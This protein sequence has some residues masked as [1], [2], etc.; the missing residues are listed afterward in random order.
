MRAPGSPL[1]YRERVRVRVFKYN[2]ARAP[3]PSPQSSPMHKG[4]G[5]RERTRK[6]IRA[7]WNIPADDVK[8]RKEKPPKAFVV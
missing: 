6:Y 1:L 5:E 4:R 7:R 8:H 3:N 2:C